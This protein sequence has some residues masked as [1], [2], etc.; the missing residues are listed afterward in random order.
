ME[1]KFSFSNTT[2]K[3]F[4]NES[5]NKVFDILVIG[6]GITGAGIALDA[7]SRGLSVCLI[8][9]HDYAW[10]T[11]S[12]STKLIHGGLRYL[13]QLE[14]GLVKEVGTE[15]A[16]VHKNARNLVLP[17]KML[18]PIVENGSLG[19]YSTSAALLVY[20]FLAG[21]KSKERRKMLTK[22]ST[23]KAEPLLD[24]KKVSGGGLYYEYRTDDARLTIEIIK[25]AVELGA[26]CI[27]YAEFINPIYENHRFAGGDIKDGIT[28]ENFEIRAKQVVNATGPWV[29]LIRKKDNSLKRKRLQLTKGV[30]IVL[31]FKALPIKQAVYF[32]VE[33]DDRMVFAIPRHGKTYVGT[34]DTIY[35]ENIDEPH[36]TKEDVAYILKATNYMFPKLNISIS[37]VESSWAG[38]RPLIYE[39]GKSPSEL[40]RKDEIFESESGLLSIAGGKLTGYRK[41]AERIVNKV[42]ELHNI[43]N[44]SKCKTEKLALYG[45]DFTSDKE[46]R[47]LIIKLTSENTK[48]KITVDIIKE[49][50]Y[51]YGTNTTDVLELYKHFLK[52][53]KDAELCYQL[54]EIQYCLENECVLKL[55]DFYIRRSSKM[56]FD[57]KRINP[58]INEVAQLVKA[59]HHYT[60]V[61]INKQIEN[62]QYFEKLA[63]TFKN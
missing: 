1:N 57:I 17:E 13:K 37:Q 24:S 30:H 6:G 25:K 60:D 26:V 8:E 40:S 9:K 3:H 4:I 42:V 55:E 41:M 18:L 28:N 19:Y 50:V 36:A 5:Q 32:D 54:A 58:Y 29:D 52:E 31:P 10:G 38:L 11:S 34:T 61:E 53:K 43:K 63:L 33:E 15:R 59:F 56:Y 20:D 44:A 7:V 22:R 49:W 39:D 46:I 45:S 51:R 14:I 35:S 16:I 12:R 47:N 27:N 48:H 23:L 21:V 2:R 62:V